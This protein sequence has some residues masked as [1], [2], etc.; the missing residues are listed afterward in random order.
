M[1]AARFVFVYPVSIGGGQSHAAQIGH[2]DRVSFGELAR[3]SGAH[4]SPGIGKAV[5]Q[6]N[7]RA[8]PRQHGRIA[9]VPFVC[10]F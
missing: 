8:V 9:V 6:D 5:K 1:S 4:M 3:G 2:Y 10:T 7:R